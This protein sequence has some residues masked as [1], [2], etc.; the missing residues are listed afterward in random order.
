MTWLALADEG[1]AMRAFVKAYGLVTKRVRGISVLMTAS[2][3]HYDAV[4]GP[5]PIGL[6]GDPKRL[7]RV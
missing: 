3:R 7:R 6:Y 4:Q 5:G 2:D 1:D